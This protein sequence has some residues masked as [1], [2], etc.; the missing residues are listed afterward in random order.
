MFSLYA[1]DCILLCVV[2]LYYYYI[3]YTENVISN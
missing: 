2:A 3:P 1:L